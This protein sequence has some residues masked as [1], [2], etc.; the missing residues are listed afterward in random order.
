MELGLSG[1]KAIVTG[2][3]RG[4]GK[5]IASQLAEEGVDLVLCARGEATL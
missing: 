5:A 1:R 3:S 4:L 2:A